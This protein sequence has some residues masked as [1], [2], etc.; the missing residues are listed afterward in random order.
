MCSRTNCPLA[1]S[2]YATVREEEGK[3]YLFIK[4]IERAAFP[5]KLWEKVELSKNYQEALQE[6]DQRLMYWPWHMRDRCKRRLTKITQY[7]IRMRK[8]R[9]RRQKKLVTMPRK[10]E[11]RERR[12]ETKALIA[13]KLDVAIERELLER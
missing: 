11:R 7:L 13:A 5:A 1:N 2:N 9:T 6:I 12:R 10:V 4:T 3:C 8:L